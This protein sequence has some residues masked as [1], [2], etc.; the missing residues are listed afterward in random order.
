[1]NKTCHYD[2]NDVANGKAFIFYRPGYDRYTSKV[3]YS[4]AA[5]DI[6]VRSALVWTKGK[7]VA[8]DISL[9]CD[10]WKKLLDK[11]FEEIGGES[12]K[13]PEPTY[14]IDL[15]KSQKRRYAVRGTML[16][17]SPQNINQAE[18]PHLFILDRTHSDHAHIAKSFRKWHLNRRE[19]EIVQLLLDDHSN[20]EIALDLNLSCNT[21]KG[22][23]KLLMRK[24]DVN[25][26]AGIISRLLY[27][28][29]LNVNY[30]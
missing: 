21:I 12:E 28:N 15:I 18:W 5:R 23:L 14:F 4:P 27:L 24:L 25:S 10:K 7:E 19:Q 6:L 26:R 29:N 16:S 9:F 2:Y 22:Y 17:D 1:M 30:S 13:K 20:K 8:P 3:F 11:K